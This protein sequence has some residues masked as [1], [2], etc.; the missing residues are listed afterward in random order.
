MKSFIK[1]IDLIPDGYKN[2]RQFLNFADFLK[3][4]EYGLA[5]ESLIELA[6]EIEYSFPDGFWNN[7]I[8]IATKIGMIKEADYCKLKILKNK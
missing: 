3:H 1:A 4:N 8:I 5:L 2:Q 6:D 7:L